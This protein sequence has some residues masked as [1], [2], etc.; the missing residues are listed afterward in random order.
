MSSLSLHDLQGI[1][2]YSNTIRIPSGHRL[3]MQGTAK[4]PT[5]TDATKPGSPAVGDVGYNTSTATLEFYDGEDWL[6]I[7]SSVKDGSSVAKAA[8]SAQAIKDVQPSATSGLYYITVAG[9]GAVQVYCD[10]S[11]DGGGWTFVYKTHHANSHTF[12]WPSS[13]SY[14]AANINPR[15]ASYANTECNLPNKY[16]GYGRTETSNATEF[17]IE[18]YDYGSGN[19]DFIYKYSY[20]AESGAAWDAGTDSYQQNFI[21]YTL[22]VTQIVDRCGSN[23]GT[24][25][26][27]DSVSGRGN[28]TYWFDKASP[29]P[30][31]SDGNWDVANPKGSGTPANKKDANCNRYGGGGPGLYRSSSTLLWVR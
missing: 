11:T 29:N 27:T 19:A 28:G 25:P 20:D 30:P 4:L 13:N 16:S 24:R 5:W 23:N 8:N 17:L 6:Q 7:I 9:Q 3:D 10:M 18:G 12:V 2:T 31:G 21:R 15:D 22:P 26:T 14:Y 1:S